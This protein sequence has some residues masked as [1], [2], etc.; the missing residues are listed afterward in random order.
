M[1]TAS[2]ARVLLRLSPILA[3]FGST[4]VRAADEAAPANPSI[5]INVDQVKGQSS[6]TLYGLMTEEINYSYD[7]GLYAE[8]IANRTFQEKADHPQRWSLIEDPGASGTMDFD[9]TE[10]YNDNLPVSLKLTATTAA[11]KLRVGFSNNGFWGIPVQPN[12]TYHASFYAKASGNFTGPIAVAISSTKDPV[13]YAYTTVPKL[14]NTWQKYEV[15]LKTGADVKPT[16]DADFL[17]WTTSPGTAWFSLVSLFPPTYHNRTNGMRIDIMQLL[18]DYKPAFLRFPGGNYVEGHTPETRFNWKQTIGDISQRPGH[19]DDSWNYYS[20]DGVGLLEFLEWCEDLKMNPVLAVPAGLYLGGAG[21]GGTPTVSAGPDLEPLVQ[22]ALDEIEYVTGDVNTKWGAER[23][24]DGHPAPFKLEYIEIGNEDNLNGGPGSYAARFTQFYNAIKAKYPQIKVIATTDVRSRNPDMPVATPDVLDRHLYTTSEF[25]SEL[26]ATSYDKTDRNGPKIFEGEWATR[27]GVPTPNFQGALGDAA[28]MTG[29]ER[30]SDIVNMA[31]YAPLFVNV[32][33]PVAN[34]RDPG[35]SMQWRSDLIGYD[36]LTS[37]GSPPFYAQKMFN[38]Y[39]GDQI[40]TTSDA[41][42]APRDFQQPGNRGGAPTTRQVPSL[43]YVATRD[44]KTGTVYL[45][46]VN[47]LATPQTVQVD[48]KGATSVAAK[49]ESVIM[50][51]DSPTD[52]NSIT[53]P[54]KIVPVVAQ[55]TGFGSSFSRT[56]APYSIN[57]LEIGTK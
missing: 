18:A 50:K 19:V 55:E 57:I 24:K 20:T 53:E 49:G 22:D 37:Y 3:L 38:N 4:A 13:T 8:L 28:Y 30:N 39:R 12:T 51:A 14:T 25:Q 46:L 45:N 6:P 34:G 41:G 27:V 44:S 10:K 36:A 26:S 33:N 42:I 11:D 43:F 56:L 1:K 35:T 17:V 32:S 47:P 15:T 7:G 5:T 54:T 40:L 23:A 29:L 16:K 31:S 9:T 2:L 48:L 52:T 21:P